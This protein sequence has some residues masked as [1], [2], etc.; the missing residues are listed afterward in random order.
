MK[1][2][3]ILVNDYNFS[4]RHYQGSHILLGYED[5]RLVAIVR[6]NPI[7]VEPLRSMLKQAGIPIDDFKK[8]L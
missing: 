3:K 7:K 1:I 6:A 5:G 8:R 2:F 4:A